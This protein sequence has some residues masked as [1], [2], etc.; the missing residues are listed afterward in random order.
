MKNA[1]LKISI[2][3]FVISIISM[4]VIF[5]DNKKITSKSTTE[6][7]ENT[8]KIQLIDSKVHLLLN[9]SIIKTYEIVPEILPGEDI[10]LLSNG[11]IVDSE[12]EADSIVEDFDG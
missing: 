6:F 12:A 8:M 5:N 1:R 9:D 7:S 2:I 4:C 11:I 3:A 10:L